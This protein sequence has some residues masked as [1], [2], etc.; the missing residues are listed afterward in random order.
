LRRTRDALLI[1]QAPMTLNTTVQVI[2]PLLV[3]ELE[4]EVFDSQLVRLT[5]EV[6]EE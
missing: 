3:E 1:E 6:I 4:K 2:L 5:H